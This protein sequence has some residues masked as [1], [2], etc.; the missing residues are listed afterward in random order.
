MSGLKLSPTGF[1][2][3]CSSQVLSLH[4]PTGQ[5]QERSCRLVGTRRS[6]GEGGVLQVKFC[7]AS[8]CWM[9]EVKES[10]KETTLGMQKPRQPIHPENRKYLPLNTKKRCLEGL[11]RR[12]G[13]PPSIHPVPTSSQPGWKVQHQMIPPQNRWKQELGSLTH[14]HI[15]LPVLCSFLP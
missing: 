11:S 12:W 9:N 5:P 10:T 15:P 1:P 7:T 14:S 13:S 3:C 4:H 2:S 6:S 8:L